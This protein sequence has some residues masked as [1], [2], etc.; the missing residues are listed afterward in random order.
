LGQ[1][2]YTP[3]IPYYKKKKSHILRKVEYDNLKYDYLFVF[4]EINFMGRCK[5]NFDRLL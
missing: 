5:I 3:F 2:K 1:K 4:F